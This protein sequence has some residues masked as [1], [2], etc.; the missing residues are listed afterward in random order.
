MGE[1]SKC[2]ISKEIM[3]KR[4]ICRK[5]YNAQRVTKRKNEKLPTNKK[6]LSINIDNCIFPSML[7][8][9]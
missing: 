4:T 3:P 8:V 7:P 5:C 6:K 9:Y 2:K 1:C